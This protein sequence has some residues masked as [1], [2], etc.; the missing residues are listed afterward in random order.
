[1]RTGDPRSSAGGWWDLQAHNERW[2]IEKRPAML[3]RRLLDCQDSTDQYGHM[4]YDENATGDM[5]CSF[6]WQKQQGKRPI[7]AWAF[8]FPSVGSSAKGPDNVSPAPTGLVQFIDQKP[9][10][11]GGANAA[12]PQGEACA[13][14]PNGS[15]MRPV[16]DRDMVEDDRFIPIYP[17][18][19][20]S[21]SGDPLWPKFPKGYYGIALSATNEAEQ[22]EYFFPTD[23]RLLAV[24][25]NGDVAMG[26]MVCDM[27]KGFEIDDQAIARLQAFMWVVKSP[28]GCVDFFGENSIAW[29]IGPTGCGDARGGLVIDTFGPP[30]GDGDP[31]SP[32]VLPSTPT[33]GGG[34]RAG[35]GVG[36]TTA[37]PAGGGGGQSSGTILATV[38]V[39]ASGP[40]D[41]GSLNDPHF[42]GVDADGHVINAVHLS[43]N[44]FFRG[45]GGDG[46]LMFEG[47]YRD[48]EEYDNVVRVHLGWDDSQAHPFVC[49]RRFGKWRWYTTSP[50]NIPTTDFPKYKPKPDPDPDPKK[51][52]PPDFPDS[53]TGE[54]GPGNPKFKPQQDPGGNDPPI[55]PPIQTGAQFNVVPRIPGPLR[56][57]PS[58]QWINAPTVQKSNV[59]QAKPKKY[60]ATDL[61][62]AVSTLFA[63]P[64][65]AKEDFPDARAWFDAPKGMKEYRAST[66][67]T[68]RIESFGQQ[69]DTEWAYTYRPG[70]F[71]YPTADGGFVVMPP[72]VDLV[73]VDTSFVPDGITKSSTYFAT[74]TGTYFASGLPDLATGTMKTAHRWSEDT[75]GNLLFEK[76]NSSAVAA[77]A[78]KLTSDQLVQIPLGTSTSFANAVGV[79]G[80]DLDVVGT[81]AVVTQ[82]TLA[83]VPLAANALDTNGKGVR[84]KAWGTTAANANTKTIRLKFGTDVLK[85]NDVTTAPNNQDWEI[86]AE[87]YRTGVATQEAVADMLVGAAPQT[88]DVTQ[89][90][91]VETAAVDVSL[92]GQNGVATANDIVCRGLVVEYL[93]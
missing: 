56:D 36:N 21:K 5:I 74:A 33:G 25:R 61:S 17:N 15:P 82:E 91:Q 55:N 32:P 58:A 1:M 45:G 10:A 60:V 75:S 48:G 73:D 42:I 16:R 12:K 54:P 27:A 28:T 34:G 47:A 76:M 92:T 78:L 59:N 52:P 2:E 13:V 31:K 86:D 46:P 23:P 22:I 51:K 9:V 11:T 64:Q 35:G 68:A 71:K 79:V 14:L 41:V 8:A 69:A 66:P 88:K 38:S 87:V 18:F 89:P 26:S 72:E 57:S 44:S 24:N 80:R 84:I 85:S 30:K 43:T 81:T 29:N 4:V 93:S 62:R 63:R 3:A 19:P 7:P 20:K 40:F 83:T 39:Q 77:N 90:R 49:G 50:D 53:P 67:L 6:M 70:K 65:L 37:G